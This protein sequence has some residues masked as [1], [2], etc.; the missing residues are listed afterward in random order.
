L[1]WKDTF[2]DPAYTQRQRSYAKSLGNN[3]V[4]TPQV[5]LNGKRAIVGNGNG[6]LNRAVAAT[7]RLGNMPSIAV[8]DGKVSIGNG[9]GS[10]Q[11][12]LVRYDPR[13]QMVAI[14]AGENNGRKLPHRNIV[15]QLIPL[16]EWKDRATSVNLPRSPDPALRSV[17]LLQSG[18]TGPIISAK[19][20]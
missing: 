19:Q 14:Q 1:G 16:G 13:S 15:R 5:V 4:Y 6:E 10:A 18:K 3:S 17:I 8:S 9:K 12:L 7:Q 20:L 2:A 11:I